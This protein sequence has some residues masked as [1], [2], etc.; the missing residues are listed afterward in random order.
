VTECLLTWH[1]AAG[2]RPD[3]S[4]AGVLLAA[5]SWLLENGKVRGLELHRARFTAACAEAGGLAESEMDSY[6][7]AV[8]D[9]LPR[10]GE[11]FPRVELVAE[12]AGTRLRL[13]IRPAPART[14]ET[15]VWVPAGGDPRSVPRRKGPDLERLAGICKQAAKAGANEALLTTPSGLVLE[16]A[17][18]ALLWWEGER[19]CVPDPNLRLLPSVT[20]TLI[21][22][23]AGERGIDVHHSRRRLPELAGHE[24]W[25]ANALHG[26][27]PVAGWVGSKVG[28]GLPR[29]APHWRQ[30]WDSCAE[31]LPGHAVQAAS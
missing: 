23:E 31:A 10:T 9:R 4:G 8:L 1:P 6:W 25:L 13:R 18:S 15:V 17:N 11:W 20:A 24:V 3:Q 16:G 12:K 22:R 7:Q 26:I 30:W 28:T 14:T 5:D 27:R 2:L 29:R 21:R 19:L